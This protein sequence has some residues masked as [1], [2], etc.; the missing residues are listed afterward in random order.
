VDLPMTPAHVLRTVD[1]VRP[2][3]LFL[4]TLLLEPD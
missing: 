1:G 2:L 3:V 4:I